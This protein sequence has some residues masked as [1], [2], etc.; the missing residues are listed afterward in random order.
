MQRQLNTTNV[1]RII[2]KY[3][4][5]LINKYCTAEEKELPNEIKALLPTCKQIQERFY[6]HE[7]NVLKNREGYIEALEQLFSL[8]ILLQDEEYPLESALRKNLIAYLLEELVNHI[9]PI[10]GLI[11]M[12]EED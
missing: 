7:E 4:K 6:M 12:V 5:H 3:E 10:I 9:S 11:R 2:D 8:S 1:Q